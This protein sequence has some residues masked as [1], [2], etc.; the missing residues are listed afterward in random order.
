MLWVVMSILFPLAPLLW[1]YSWFLGFQ[2]FSGR[3]VRIPILTRWAEKRGKLD[4]E[5]VQ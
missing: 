5:A 1:M 2:A 3:R 4:I